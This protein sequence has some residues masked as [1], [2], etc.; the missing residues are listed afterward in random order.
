MLP[1]PSPVPSL[2][3]QC[4]LLEKLRS[5]CPAKQQPSSARPR[6][7][8][9]LICFYGKSPCGGRLCRYG[10]AS[11]LPLMHTTLLHT[12][13]GDASAGIMSFKDG[14]VLIITE[15]Q[16]SGWWIADFN[17]ATGVV[18]ST[19]A[20]PHRCSSDPNALPLSDTLSFC[21]ELRWNKPR[22][23]LR[24]PSIARWLHCRCLSIARVTPPPRA[25]GH[26]QSVATIKNGATS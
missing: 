26:E 1:P 11:M 4:R 17:G 12:S 14:D 22:G 15:Q 18:P 19:C 7:L 24:S 16:D 3:P 13:A 20:R 10:A 25:A 21:Q 9:R 23:G 8:L 2:L 6:L 5:D